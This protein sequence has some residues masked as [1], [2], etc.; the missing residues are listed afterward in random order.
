MYEMLIDIYLE[1]GLYKERLFSVTKKGR[2]GAEAIQQMMK[3]YRSNPPAN[4]NGS[5]VLKIADYQVQE[6]KN[7][8]KGTTTKIN[9]P[10]SNIDTAFRNRTEDQ[11]LF[12]RK[13]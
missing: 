13:E 10:R 2:E 8:Q 9:L 6:E 1:F 12:W 7:I 5:K 4:I 3:D 11:I